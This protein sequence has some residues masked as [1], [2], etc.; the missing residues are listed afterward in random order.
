M[1]I[2]LDPYITSFTKKINSRYIK[3]SNLEDYIYDLEAEGNLEQNWK[4]KS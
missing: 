1:K 3:N 2:K 4:P